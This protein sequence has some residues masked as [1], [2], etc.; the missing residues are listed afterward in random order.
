VTGE[1]DLENLATRL[2]H[3]FDT[4]FVVDGYCLSVTTSIG[5]ALADDGETTEELLAAADAAMYEAKR[6]GGGTFSLFTR[7]VRAR[8]VRHLELELELRDALAADQL[9]LAYQPIVEAG[10]RQVVGAEA[11]LRWRHPALGDVSPA[12][13]VPVAEVSN[14]ILR[15]G[16]WAIDRAC[17]QAAAWWGAGQPLSVS[18]NVSARQLA[19]PVFAAHV[20]DA[21]LRHQLAPERLCLELTETA[22]VS[23]PAATR[24]VLATLSALGVRLALDDFGTGFSSLTHLLEFPVDI[25]KVDRSFIRGLGDSERCADIVAATVGL[26]A[27]LG[28]TVVAEGVETAEQRDMLEAMGCTHLQGYLF[29]RPA[30]ADELLVPQSRVVVPLQRQARSHAV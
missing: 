20:R 5:G 14:A 18:V 24:T 29:G 17:A 2:L 27:T 12:E 8:A 15:I 10:S 22:L 25:V 28:L 21:L 1:R 7:E 3:V 6:R 16:R 30:P 26:A 4:P 11:L 19:D 23:D 13:F 9:R